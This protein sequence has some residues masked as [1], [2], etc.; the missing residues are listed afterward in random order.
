[1]PLKE[2]EM[3][4]ITKHTPPASNPLNSIY[5]FNNDIKAAAFS[6]WILAIIIAKICKFLSFAVD[7]K[8]GGNIYCVMKKDLCNVVIKHTKHENPYVDEPTINKMIQASTSKPHFN[9]KNIQKKIN[10]EFSNKLFCLATNS[11]DNHEIIKHYREIQKKITENNSNPPTT[12]DIKDRLIRYAQSDTPEAKYVIRLLSRLHSNKCNMTP[13]MQAF[14]KDTADTLS[15][16]SRKAA[17]SMST[18]STNARDAL[19]APTDIIFD[20]LSFLEK[21]P[22]KGYKEI[23]NE[24]KHLFMTHNLTI[25]GAREFLNRA[26]SRHP[27]TTLSAKCKALNNQLMVKPIYTQLHD[28]IYGRAFD[29]FFVMELVKNPPAEV[30]KAMTS[31]SFG[32][33]NYLK[34]LKLNKRQ[35][36]K[37]SCD[38]RE[39]FTTK[40]P[41]F[42]FPAVPE[43]EKLATT[44]DIIKSLIEYLQREKKS[45][46]ECISVPYL[47]VKISELLKDHDRTP[48]WH[49]KACDVYHA[50]LD[51]YV[52]VRLYREGDNPMHKGT[53]VALPYLNTRGAGITLHYQP[54]AADESWMVPSQR[55]TTVR[56]PNFESKGIN[57]LA[58][59]ALKTTM[60]HSVP[61]ASGMSGSTNISLQAWQYFNRNKDI[62]PTAVFLGAMMFLVYDG[63][64]SMSEPLWAA[65]IVNK[66]LNLGFDLGPCRKAEDF[67]PDYEKFQNMFK[68][69]LKNSVSSALDNSFKATVEFYNNNSYY[70]QK[71]EHSKD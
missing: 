70:A 32:V 62:D 45:G 20:L 59:K 16:I 69:E 18:P 6:N 5:S 1:M 66:S 9:L 13:G 15:T 49:Q 39:L 60:E 53:G 51:P 56:R 25:K 8:L 52:K 21:K 12:H 26:Q 33:G 67:V 23:A 65:S 44:G 37:L 57:A 24:A 46:D 10:I 3:P 14:L 43:L 29:S 41:R 7:V 64:H 35:H 68:G 19:R 30:S 34:N 31:M 2:I 58:T 47:T 48:P 54:S 63:G 22:N 36:A 4:S 61:W 71:E 42:W 50:C 40:D 11:E 55:P 28:N 38:L 17:P 27:N